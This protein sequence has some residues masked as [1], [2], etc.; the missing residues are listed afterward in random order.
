MGSDSFA[1]DD[2]AG[3][4]RHLHDRGYVVVRGALSASQCQDAMRELWKL[5]EALGPVRRDAPST[6]SPAASW[7]PMLHGGMIQY[8]GHTELQW[9]LRE[10]CAPVFAAYYGCAPD[11]LAT[12]FDGLCFMHGRRNYQG[13]GD[14]VSFLHT[15]QGPRRKGEWSIQG[16]VNLA[17]SGPQDGGLVVVPGTH[18]E[19]EAFFASHPARDA[20]GDWYKLTDAEKPRYRDRA[21]KVCAEPGDFL[22]WDSRTFHCNTVPARKDAVRACTY[23]CMLPAE[24]VAPHVR[25]KRRAACDGLRTSNHHPG[26]GFKLF[27]SIPRFVTGSRDGFL[28][29]VRALQGTHVFTELQKALRCGV[30]TLL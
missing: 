30:D 29:K 9:W 8:L 19:H 21:V 6:W 3:W 24:R 18:A 4:A 20:E 17:P 12:S 5:M 26:D 11:E 13:V 14:L 23:V 25:A 22:L 1:L 16:L 15:D 2:R 10:R 27:P 7:P 28:A